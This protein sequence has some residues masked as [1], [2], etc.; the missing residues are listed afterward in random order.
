MTNQ[1]QI[2]LVLGKDH[3]K[4]EEQLQKHVRKTYKHNQSFMIEK[5]MPPNRVNDYLSQIICSKKQKLNLK[6]Q[7]RH[8]SPNETVHRNSPKNLS[9]QETL[10]IY[11]KKEQTYTITTYETEYKGTNNV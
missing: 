2:E 11:N 7:P 8:L 10:T 6:N 9:S 1:Y 4:M 3:C 5:I